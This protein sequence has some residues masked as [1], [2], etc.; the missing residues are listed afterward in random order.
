MLNVTISI[1]T[2]LNTLLFSFFFFLFSFSFVCQLL[3]ELGCVDVNDK[4]NPILMKRRILF[5]LFPLSM[6]LSSQKK[7]SSTY[8]I[9]VQSSHY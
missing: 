7:V 8:E 9:Q 4:L 6:I 3:R 2:G 1:E 5:L